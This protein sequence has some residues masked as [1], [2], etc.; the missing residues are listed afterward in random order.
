[1]YSFKN[2]LLQE[3]EVCEGQNEPIILSL[4]VLKIFYCNESLTFENEV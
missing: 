3:R 2:I 4:T 1:M